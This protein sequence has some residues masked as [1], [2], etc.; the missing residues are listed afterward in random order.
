MVNKSEKKIGSLPKN[1]DFSFLVIFM[2][3]FDRFKT[4]KA[5]ICRFVFMKNDK[6]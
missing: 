3:H 1:D 2:I 5:N 4:R 6:L